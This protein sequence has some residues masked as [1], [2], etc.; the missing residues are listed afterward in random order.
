MLNQG[1]S[2]QKRTPRGQNTCPD[3]PFTLASKE[4][5]RGQPSRLAL[6]LPASTPDPGQLWSPVPPC[7]GAGNRLP[8]PRLGPSWASSTALG[9]EQRQR[10]P[11]HS[12]TLGR[13]HR[14]SHP[15]SLLSPTHLH[16]LSFHPAFSRSLCPQCAHLHMHIVTSGQSNGLALT[17]ACTRARALLCTLGISATCLHA[18]TPTY[19]TAVLSVLLIA[20]A[21][22]TPSSP[23]CPQ[24][25]DR[26]QEPQPNFL[27]LTGIHGASTWEPV[28]FPVRWVQMKSG[29]GPPVCSRLRVRKPVRG[30]GAQ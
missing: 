18:L 26:S 12:N 2:W 6:D 28:L 5:R 17:R 22:S 9:G 14:E 24:G 29:M 13:P 30:P 20:Q 21:G 7:G 23:P 8:Q 10:C 3:R 4:E 19:C 25:P 11:E 1:V 16:R 15:P 27:A